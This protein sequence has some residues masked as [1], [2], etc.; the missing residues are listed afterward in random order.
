MG[1]ILSIF[2]LILVA[3]LLIGPRKLPEGIE[4]LFLAWTNFRRSQHGGEPISLDTLRLQWARDQNPLHSGI[5]LLYAA[6]EHL[7]ELRRRLF[8]SLIVFGLCVLITFIF[9]DQLFALLL[10]P[11]NRIQQ[12]ATP[13]TNQFQLTQNVDISSTV[14][15]S[16][17]AQPISI[18]ITIPKGTILPV[19]Y[20]QSLDKLKPVFFKPTE[21]FITTFK[22]DLFAGAGMALPIVLYEIVAFLMPGLLPNEK[23]YVFFLV[24]AIAVFFA[25]GVVFAYYLM[26]PFALNFLFTFGSDIATPLPSINEY[27]SF[28]TSV[29]FWVGLTFQTPLIIFFLAKVRLVNVPKLKRF[30]RFAIVGA[31]IVAAFVTPTPDP[32]NQAI[33]ALPIILL[34]ELGII[35]ARFA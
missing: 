9:S 12:P 17:T 5:Q 3:I 33:V 19:T 20:A 34:Y 15:I 18:T 13:T 16:E 25:A 7:A 35:L 6:T 2:L 24:P 14:T 8:I 32:I 26:L 28:V 22:V 1:D 10:A 23:R 11:L 27:I 4:A 31:F 29:L 21:M 30:R